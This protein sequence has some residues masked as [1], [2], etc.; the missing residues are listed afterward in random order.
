MTEQDLL[1]GWFEEHRTHLRAVAQRMLGSWHE[2]DDAVQETWLRF[3]RSDT[4]DVVNLRGW[5][6]T[7]I[8]RICLD[9]LRART[10]RREQPFDLH[11]PDPIVVTTDAVDPEGE[12]IQADSVG[13]AL[14]VVLER[15]NP[16]ERLVFVLHDT[17]S[18]PIDDIAIMLDRSPNATKQLASRARARVRGAEPTSSADR[19]R[20]HDVIEA[21][22]NAARRGEFDALV[23][24]LHPGVVMRAD[25]G[26]ST[27]QATAT[28]QGQ[29]AVAGR[30]LLFAR[31]DAT[32]YPAWVNGGAGVVITVQQRPI[33][34]MKFTVKDGV[35]TAIDALVDAD[36]IGELDL[37]EFSD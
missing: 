5:L 17:F 36:R 24:L 26:I 37:S 11:L 31:P 18:V 13:S 32:V 28:V 2:A 19:R 35:I 9:M 23:T 7:V 33:S 25:G 6:T 21:F 4:R 29:A 20:H 34:I 30:A 12:A 3:S 1:V 10:A 27:P 16:A 15:L 14:N 22:F 8:G